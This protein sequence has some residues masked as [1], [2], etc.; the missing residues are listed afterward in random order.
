MKRPNCL[1]LTAWIIATLLM[2][3]AGPAWAQQATGEKKSAPSPASQ[4]AAATSNPA[5]N[6]A[7]T[8]ASPAK[9]KKF[10]GRLPAHF[11][12]VVDEEQR[13]AIYAIQ[14]E[15]STKID[16]L[17]AQLEAMTQER[18]GKIAAVLTASQREKIESLKT[19]AR[20]KRTE[21]SQEKQE[22]QDE[23]SQ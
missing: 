11:S 22:K 14:E 16:S 17:K 4:T 8:E 10:R 12:Q 20:A 18:D 23:Q 19:T 7:P 21:K 13:K 9:A 1:R 2:A 15:Y 6:P 3:A 5:A